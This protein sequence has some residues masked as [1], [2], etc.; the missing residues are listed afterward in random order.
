M[1]AFVLRLFGSGHQF[2]FAVTCFRLG[3]VAGD[4][5]LVIGSVT[6]L[7]VALAL[8]DELLLR[9]LSWKCQST[10]VFGLADILSLVKR[11]GIGRRY[12]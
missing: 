1:V 2:L 5:L 7:R 12:R 4:V 8:G 9:Q 6:F 11:I 10:F 3:F